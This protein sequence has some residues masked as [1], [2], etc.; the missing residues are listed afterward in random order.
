MKIVIT[1]LPD[2]TDYM[3][4]ITPLQLSS[5][6]NIICILK[7][8]F[9]D[10]DVIV[11]FYLSEISENTKIVSGVKLTSDAL[12]CLPKFDLG[13]NYYIKCVNIDGINEPI[14]KNNVHKF[15]LQFT[16][17]DGTEWDIKEIL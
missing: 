12:L 5:D 7:Q 17:E 4:F 1:K 9:R 3:Q 14:T 15:Y 13:F 11:D 10:D 16:T 8:L 6:V 2:I